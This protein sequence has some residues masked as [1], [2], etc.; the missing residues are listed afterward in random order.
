MSMSITV[1]VA[2]TGAAEAPLVR[3]L[4][5]APGLVVV[6]RCADLVELLAA[7][8]AGHGRAALV[9][10]DL[11]R[12]D[13][14]AVARLAGAG[15]A[16]VGVRAGE[17][18]GAHAAE[19]GERLAALGVAH[20]VDATAGALTLADAVGVAVQEASRAARPGGWTSAALAD[21]AAA[22]SPAPPLGQGPRPAAGPGGHPE[23]GRQP[24]QR[25]GADPGADPDPGADG[26][27]GWRPQGWEPRR[28]SARPVPA[29]APARGRTVAVWGTE[30]APGRTMVATSLAAELAAAGEGTLLVDAD[31]CSASVAL[32]LGLLDESAGVAA[33]CRSAASGSLDAT[34]LAALAPVTARGLRVLTG[35]PRASRWPE[36]GA[37]SLARVLDVARDAH[38]WTVVDCAAGIEQ[39]EELAHDTAAPRRHAATLTA[40]A[41]ADEVLV[42]GAADPLGLQRLVRSVQ[43]LAEAVPGARPTVVVTKVR[44]SSVGPSPRRQVTTTLARYAGIHDPVLLPDDRGTYDAALLAGRALVEHA[45]TSPLRRAVQDLAEH[46]RER[47]H[48]ADRT[49]RADHTDHR[50]AHRTP[51][52]RRRGL[53]ARMHR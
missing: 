3:A 16:V 53:W 1:L 26:E 46:L 2:V 42:V 30:G 20:V 25:T 40:L 6:R 39:D 44:A 7:A 14:D 17:P 18:G 36:V 19:Q 5:A 8:G 15:T 32:A 10:P 33:A 11:H 29:P 23:P 4:D 47:A 52:R 22:L 9:S 45:P 12:L 34:R 31:T 48:R 35:L 37:A 43:D 38:A 49:D 27:D 50:A 41:D 13:R 21:P 24:G 28:A 51:A